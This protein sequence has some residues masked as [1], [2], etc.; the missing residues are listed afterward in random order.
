MVDFNH[1][2]LIKLLIN[3]ENQINYK[4]FEFQPINHKYKLGCI[5]N[6][7]KHSNLLNIYRRS[8]KNS[9]FNNKN[10]KYSI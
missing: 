8:I 5:I 3:H 2:Y 10:R 9:R 4:L 7:I 1:W 6:K